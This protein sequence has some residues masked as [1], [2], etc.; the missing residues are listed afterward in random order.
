MVKAGH[1]H[2]HRRTCLQAEGWELLGISPRAHPTIE[3][4]HEN[5]THL[6]TITFS[7]AIAIITLQPLGPYRH[8]AADLGAVA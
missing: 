6:D 5:V 1:V 3:I 2:S 4:H 7:T 8:R